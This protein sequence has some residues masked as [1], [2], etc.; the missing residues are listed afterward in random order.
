[1]KKIKYIFFLF[2]AISVFSSC[3]DMLEEEQ[4]TTITT[5]FLYS[6]KEALERAVIALYNVDRS[7]FKKD[8]QSS[9]FA[10]MLDIGTDIDW[11][12]A[13][14]GST[15]ANYDALNSNNANV[16]DFWKHQYRIIGK[17]NEILDAANGMDQQDSLVNRIIGEASL[18]RAHAYYWLWVKF[19]RIYLTTT[20]TTYNNLDDAVFKP[21]TNEEVFNRMDSDL[22]V[23]IEKLAWETPSSGGKVQYGR[24]NK[25]VAKHIK[26]LVAMWEENWDEAIRQT[27]DIFNPIHGYALM[28][29]PKNVFEGANLNNS[30]AIFAYQFLD[31]IGGGGS[32]SDGLYMGHRLAI[33]TVAQYRIKMKYCDLENG[34][35]GWG[36]LM[37]NN[38]L[39][40]LYQN[41]NVDKRY[42]Q[43]FRHYF[44]K[45]REDQIPATKHS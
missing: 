18:F 36:R 11:F 37:P 24:F 34:G 32:L 13:G 4:K 7:Y 30:E 14:G 41:K 40:S 10:Y 44:I 38:Y 17:C 8:E 19:G 27:E 45:E 26:A 42:Q 12:R 16:S 23:A 25:A 21:A 33:I 22:N 28:P 43:Y 20:P 3:T 15:F 31:G 1:M 39:L 6:N 35:Y 9:P 2:C 5:E 29:E